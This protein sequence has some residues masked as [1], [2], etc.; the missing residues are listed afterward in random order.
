MKLY[1]YRSIENAILELENGTFHFST[2]EELNDPLEGY[3]KIYWQG[4]NIAWEGLLKNYICSVD[5]AISLFLLQADSDMLHQN[6][7]VW[8]IHQNDHVPLG[9]IWTQLGEDFIS[10]TEVK[11]LISFYGNNGF[12]VYKD[13]LTFL[14]RYFHTKALILCIKSNMQHGII[15]EN[16]G[17]RLLEVFKHKATD[18]PEELLEKELPSDEERARLTKTMKNYIQDLLEYFY[19]SKSDIPKL[20]SEDSTQEHIGDVSKEENQMRNWLSIVVDFP[21]TYTSQLMDL[22]YPAAYITCFSAQN[23]DSVMWGNYADNHKGVCLIYETDI[24]DTIEVKDKSG[25]KTG[26]NGEVVS[27]YSWIKKSIQKVIYGGDICERNFFESLGR[28]TFSQIRSWLTNDDETSDCYNAYK[29]KEEWH[30]QYW[31]IFQLK[32]CRKMKEWAYEEEYR[33]IIDNTFGDHEKPEERNLP[34]NSKALKGVFFG[35]R[36]SEYDKKRVIDAIRKSNYNSVLF[37]QAE[38]DEEL[39]KINVREK[40]VWNQKS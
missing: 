1:H 30:K 21:D 9:R 20:N 34:Y 19:L 10:D 18:I 15:D 27:I 2:R 35:I 22:I 8:D 32:N 7:L 24:N 23:N 39:Q 4:D 17:Q 26:E 33:L 5:N 29:N 36:T 11:K 25:Y 40:N 28:L 31:E 38:Y 3:L 12:K 6:I 14:L 37:Y 16:E 13:E